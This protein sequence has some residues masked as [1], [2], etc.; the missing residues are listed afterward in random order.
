MIF[1]NPLKNT[2]GEA[3]EGCPGQAAGGN[4][5]VIH[6]RARGRRGEKH[7]ANQEIAKVRSEMMKYST[8][9]IKWEPIC[10]KTTSNSGS[11]FSFYRIPILP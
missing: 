8:F 3:G 7:W 6:D 11:K 4:A 1:A 9:S 10:E 2:E 5:F